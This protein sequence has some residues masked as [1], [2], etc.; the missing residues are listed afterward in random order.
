MPTEA[1]VYARVSTDMQAQ[2]GGGLKDQLAACLE[3]C[4]RQ[5]W[6]VLGIYRDEGVTG[7]VADRPQF[8]AA[9]AALPPGGV[10]VVDRWDRMS[11]DT[12]YR[13]HL[14][15]RLSSRGI[16]I[17]SREGW[18]NVDTAAGF[19]QYATD[20]AFS[21]H[22]RLLISERTAAAFHRQRREGRQHGGR[23]PFGYKRKDGEL[24]IDPVAAATVSDIFAWAEQ[25]LGRGAIAKRL[26]D[27]GVTRPD[28]TQRPWTDSTV[29]HIL[30]NMV[31]AG[32]V[33]H[34]YEKALRDDGRKPTWRLLP[35]DEWETHEGN[36]PH[37]VPPA[38]FDRVQDIL[39]SRS[40]KVPTNY[41]HEFLL[42]GLL[43]CPG[44]GGKMHGSHVTSGGKRYPVYRCTKNTTT[45]TCRAHCRGAE[46]WEGR[47]QER[48]QWIVD[49]DPRAQPTWRYGVAR[50]RPELERVGAELAGM[51]DRREA[52]YEALE[53][54]ALLPAKYRERVE[55]LDSREAELLKQRAGL[56][57]ERT[58]D[59]PP[60]TV[61]AILEVVRSG[62][63]SMARKRSI[64]AKVFEEIRWKG[65][66]LEIIF[67]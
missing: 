55:R 37:I 4:D 64:L 43:R 42:S 66:D 50:R 57:Q 17:Y 11:R 52:L 51:D 58:S 34:R 10:F 59:E 14:A 61:H 7:A 45:R 22:A 48:V 2:Q 53:T 33:A 32:R 44:C 5:D 28:G 63:Y 25:G 49:G 46:K 27:S 56:Q 29:A 39:R 20:A 47:F 41:G 23:D 1:I 62:R 54:R 12:A 40:Y 3:I 26:T 21:E 65:D 35:P 13:L 19:L 31:V 36:H 60:E 67:R 30:R 6:D 9:L 15:R 8:Q 24:I 16:R 38:Q 18:V